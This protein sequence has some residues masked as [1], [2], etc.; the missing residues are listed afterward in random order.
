MENSLGCQSLRMPALSNETNAAKASN[1]NGP[2][3]SAE[4]FCQINDPDD[5]GAIGKLNSV[6]FWY[7]RSDELFFCIVF[8]WLKKEK[9]IGTR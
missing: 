2:T 1:G 8:S 4:L 5:V 6:K 3:T 7:E 9:L